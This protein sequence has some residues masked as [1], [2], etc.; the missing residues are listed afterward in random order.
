[1]DWGQILSYLAKVDPKVY[2]AIGGMVSGGL[3]ARQAG[4]D[5]QQAAMSN[6]INTLL[7]MQQQGQSNASNTLN[8]LG[9]PLGRANEIGNFA[10]R[11]EFLFGGPGGTTQWFKPG[12]P[13]VAQ[14]M[15][16]MPNLSAARPFFSDAAMLDS[17]RMY[18]TAMARQSGGE[19]TPN[20]ANAGFGSEPAS[21][22]Q[23]AVNLTAQ[24][25]R[26]QAQQ[27]QL[28]LTQA[29]SAQERLAGL[30]E[31]TDGGGTSWWRKLIGIAAP[32]AL[33]MFGP[34]GTAAGLAI[35]AGIGAGAGALAGG[36]WR[37]AL[38]G[39]ASGGLAGVGGIG[40][41]AGRG[42]GAARGV[43]G[44][45]GPTANTFWMPR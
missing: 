41:L 16:P 12:D 29:L 2:S 26:Q 31:R 42:A 1:M 39:A 7:S 20:Y 45:T 40:A 28:A 27:Q 44:I 5:R 11:R 36:G 23:A 6:V 37:G 24:Q 13:Y 25:A 9:S 17:L 34:A 15:G 43:A 18:D 30:K 14:A 10:T 3:N 32:I 21:A 4:Q 19:I 22:T 8:A 38:A 35:R 33:S